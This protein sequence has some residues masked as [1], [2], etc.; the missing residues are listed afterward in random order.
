MR[1]EEYVQLSVGFCSNWSIDDE[2]LFTAEVHLS[3]NS[4]NAD[5]SPILL[6]P[7]G[8]AVIFVQYE[9]PVARV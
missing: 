8:L 2:V 1:R 5:D 6:S 4:S 9:K 7:Q 3:K